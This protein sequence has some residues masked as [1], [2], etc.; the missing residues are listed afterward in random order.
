MAHQRDLGHQI[1]GPGH[2]TLINSEKLESRHSA[3]LQISNI[4]QS[5]SLAA[6]HRAQSRR[7]TSSLWHGAGAVSRQQHAV[8]SS[9]QHPLSVQCDC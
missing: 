3:Q 8:P 4:S 7:F 9:L 6:L 2:Q 1:R 5:F